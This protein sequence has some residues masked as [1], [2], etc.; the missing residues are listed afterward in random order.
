MN[1][2]NRLGDEGFAPIVSFE[3]TTFAS[4]KLENNPLP[5]KSVDERTG[6]I[7]Y[8]FSAGSW[9]KTTTN[10]GGTFSVAFWGYWAETASWSRIFDFGVD[11]NNQNLMVTNNAGS[12][13]LVFSVRQGSNHHSV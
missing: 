2:R 11:Q 7:A 4:E 6:L 5:R 1:S 9:L 10:F 3:Q 13:N 8:Y 12:R